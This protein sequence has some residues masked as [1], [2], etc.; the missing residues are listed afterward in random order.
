MISNTG[1]HLAGQRDEGGRGQGAVSVN[2][3][4][5]VTEAETGINSIILQTFINRETLTWVEG[6]FMNQTI[7]DKI[8]LVHNSKEEKN[9]NSAHVS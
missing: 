2:P 5:R 8:H 7:S 9:I 3:P 4:P 1:P 6:T